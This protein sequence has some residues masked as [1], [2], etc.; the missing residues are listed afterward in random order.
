MSVLLTLHSIRMMS[1]V[2]GCGGVLLFSSVYTVWGLIAMKS[3]KPVVPL[4]HWV[5][6]ACI[7]VGGVVVSSIV[8]FQRAI[9][10]P[11]ASKWCLVLCSWACPR[12]RLFFPCCL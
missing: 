7:I 11:C 4:F 12:R 8:L 2:L 6:L 5:D 9:I 3:G 1:N 10:Y